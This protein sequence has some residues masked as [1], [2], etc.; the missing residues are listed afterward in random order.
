MYGA[1]EDATTDAAINETG[2]RPPV[3]LV[4]PEPTRPG[5][6][7]PRQSSSY[8]PVI[9]SP[10]PAWSVPGQSVVVGEGV[11]CGF[12][13]WAPDWHASSAAVLSG[14]FAVGVLGASEEGL[15]RPA[16]DFDLH[17]GAAVGAPVVSDESLDGVAGLLGLAGVVG[18]A[19]G[20]HP[21]AV[22][23]AGGLAF[24]GVSADSA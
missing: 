6:R 9:L 17:G 19:D 21:L 24:H 2:T 23:F 7:D 4:R 8:L 18:L 15:V 22:D 14:A 11:C 5:P 1:S 3:V 10:F 20:P 12:A 13:D 16:V